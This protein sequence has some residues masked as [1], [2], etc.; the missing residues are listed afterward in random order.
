M[1][2]AATANPNPIVM[3]IVRLLAASAVTDDRV[4]FANRASA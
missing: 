3:F 1:D 2:T 4:P